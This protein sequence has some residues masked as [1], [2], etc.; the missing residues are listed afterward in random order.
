LAPGEIDYYKVRIDPPAPDAMLPAASADSRPDELVVERTV[1][2]RSDPYLLNHLVEGTPTLP[3]A[4][5]IALIA[6]AAQQ[7]RPDLA[8][9]SFERAHFH[10]FIKVYGDRETPFRVHANVVSESGGETL[11]RVRLLADFVHRNGV[12]LQ[13]DILQHEFEIR[14][15]AALRPAAT[16]HEVARFVGRQLSDPYVMAGSPV[17]LSG[18]FDTMSNIIV[19]PEFRCAECRLERLDGAAFEDGARL[20]RIMLMDSL[21]RFGAIEMTRDG[22]LPIHVPELC[23]MM[24]MYFDFSRVSASRLTGTLTLSG[25][26]PRHD[27]DK[28]YIGPVAAYDSEGKMLL[29]VE[30]GVCRRLG[31]VRNEF[32]FQATGT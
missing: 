10:R 2:I 8:I 16:G 32:V 25:A 13:K 15:A 17:R 18:P 22:S 26:N 6:D 3:G 14:M 30:D 29:S 24:R 28:L 9:V 21:W 19:G 7:L 1:S 12:I 27:G 4:H 11:L 31:E 23:D 5:I 20:Q